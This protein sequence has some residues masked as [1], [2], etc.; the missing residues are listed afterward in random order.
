MIRNYLSNLVCAWGT[1]GSNSWERSY[2]VKGICTACM[3]ACLPSMLSK[4]TL[5]IAHQGDSYSEPWRLGVL[6]NIQIE[7]RMFRI[8]CA[9]SG[10]LVVGPLDVLV[11]IQSF[12]FRARWMFSSELQMLCLYGRHWSEENGVS[13]S[14]CFVIVCQSSNLQPVNQQHVIGSCRIRTPRFNT[15]GISKFIRW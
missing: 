7:T 1:Y 11:N 5:Y 15:L 3:S 13:C 10:C 12:R 2:T 8:G 14:L 6:V 9:Y 4:Q